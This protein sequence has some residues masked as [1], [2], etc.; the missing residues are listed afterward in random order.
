MQFTSQA[1]R[2]TYHGALR[3][4]KKP[5]V[6]RP[7][8]AGMRGQSSC[9]YDMQCHGYISLAVDTTHTSFLA[10]WRASPSCSAAFGDPT[11]A[12][13]FWTV[14]RGLLELA[15]SGLKAVFGNLA[16]PPLSSEEALRPPGVESVP[17]EQQCLEGRSGLV[18]EW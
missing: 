6:L 16:A 1:T 12:G 10:K 17:G 2:R 11:H 18:G 9:G 3:S 13:Q 7:D 8:L 4:L 15:S 14:K 5:G